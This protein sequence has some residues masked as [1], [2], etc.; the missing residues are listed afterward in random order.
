MARLQK[1][2]VKKRYYGKAVY[3]YPVYSITISRKFHDLLPTFEGRDLQMDM[4]R[5]SNSLMI[6][7]TAEPGKPG[8]KRFLD[9][10]FADLGST[11]SR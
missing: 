11:K 9:K 2:L 5:R 4:E 3:Q 8:E 7:L 6:I 10:K 1:R